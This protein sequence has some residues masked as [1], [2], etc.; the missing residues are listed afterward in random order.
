M[1]R[2]MGDLL[3]VPEL[4]GAATQARRAK[5]C[6]ISTSVARSAANFIEA[7]QEEHTR[8]AGAIV[9]LC[10]D[11]AISEDQAATVLNMAPDERVHLRD[12][13]DQIAEGGE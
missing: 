6:T 8:L 13:I 4:R 10:A 5:Y 11:G 7:M 9:R 1:R 3:L 2:A 12:W